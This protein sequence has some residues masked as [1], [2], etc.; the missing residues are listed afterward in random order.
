M[1]EYFFTGTLILEHG[2]RTW[3]NEQPVTQTVGSLQPGRFRRHSAFRL[4]LAVIAQSL[5]HQLI[6]YCL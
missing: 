1:K 4:S 3:A 2:F 5:S 6:V